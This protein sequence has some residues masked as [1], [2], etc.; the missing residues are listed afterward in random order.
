MNELSDDVRLRASDDVAARA[1]DGEAVLL[2]LASGTYFGLNE[3]GARVWELVEAG[4]TVGA[5]RTTLLAE[6]DVEEGVLAT[7]LARLLAD[8]EQRG[9]VRRDVAVGGTQGPSVGGTQG[10]SAGTQG[11]SAGTQGA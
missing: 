3:V 10:P 4:T 11:P 5:L 7:D 1:L 2:D 8:L 9:L 6:F